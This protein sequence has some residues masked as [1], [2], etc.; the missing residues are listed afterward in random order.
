MS[1]TSCKY[2]GSKDVTFFVN[3]SEAGTESVA[4]GATSAAYLTQA[5]AGYAFPERSPVVSARIANYTA[6]GGALWTLRTNIRINE[7]ESMT[8]T[9]EC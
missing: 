2:A 9:F 6:E 3:D 7:N 4:G 8:H 1:Q 5:S